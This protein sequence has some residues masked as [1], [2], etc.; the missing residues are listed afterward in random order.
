MRRTCGALCVLVCVASAPLSAGEANNNHRFSIVR[1]STTYQTPSFY[2][3]WR[4]NA[5]KTKSGQGIVVSK[6]LVLTLASNVSNATSIEML[7]SSEPVPTQLKVKAVNI[8]SNLALL[9]GEMPAECV[10][11]EMPET[12]AFRRNKHLNMYWKT[13]IGLMIE[14]SAVLDRADT[15]TL[16]HTW[17]P[18][19]VFQAIRSSHPNTGFGVPVFD[20]EGIFFGLSIGGGNEYEFSIVTCD[21]IRRAFDLE[22][23]TARKDTALPGFATEP[24]MQVYYR[25][26]L[27]LSQDEGGCL[28]SK[29]FGQGSGA[30]QLLDG[31]VI[32]KIA[33]RPLDARGRYEHPDFGLLFFQHVFSEHFVDEKI[34]TLIVREGQRMQ[35]DLDLSG[36]DDSRWLIPKNPLYE[37]SEFFI[38]G[39][40]VF[41]PMTLTYLLEWGGDFRNKAPLPLVSVHEKYNTD[42]IDEKIQGFVVLSEVMPHPSNIALQQMGGRIVEQ[43]NGVPLRGLSHLKEVFDSPEADLVKL[44]LS[45]G[46]TPLWLC[47]KTLRSVDAD[48]QRIYGVSKLEHF[49]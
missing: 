25:E 46:R 4:W 16:S 39:G 6:N 41:I 49:R 28:V 43:I 19:A 24:L 40:F 32:L 5:S 44:D 31:D 47:P 8:E 14:G 33:G 42:T 34:P 17:Q 21:T 48:I 1:L 29:V 45:P 15:R 12:S 36:Y 11:M 30:S 7:L 18:H 9:E 27:G 26:K 22:Q 23:G 13:A 38:R 3:P 2:Y 35:L 10:P 20:T 37:E